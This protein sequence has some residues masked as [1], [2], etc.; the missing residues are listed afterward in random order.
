LG[1]GSKL[2]TSKQSTKC[3]QMGVLVSEWVCLPPKIG[4]LAK[5]ECHSY[6]EELVNVVPWV[7]PASVFGASVAA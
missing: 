5:P 1:R 3:F 6:T 2:K 7:V 4:T